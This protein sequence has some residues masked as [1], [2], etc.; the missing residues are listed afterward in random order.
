MYTM[1]FLTIIFYFVL[2]DVS[3][4]SGITILSR[5]R[6]GGI[7]RHNKVG[8]KEKKI[9]PGKAKTE[10]VSENKKGGRWRETGKHINV[11]LDSNIGGK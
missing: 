8:R 3:N 5:G 9:C 11:C 10:K 4:H 1:G 7:L 2:V 6:E